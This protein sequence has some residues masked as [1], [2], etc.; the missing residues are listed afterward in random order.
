MATRSERYRY[1]QDESKSRV[2]RNR[3][4]Y[5]QIYANDSY[6]QNDESTPIEHTNEINI[7]KVKELL[8]GREI[9]RREMK[10]RELNMLKPEKEDVSAVESDSPEK[11]YDIN[12]YLT[13]ASSERTAEPYHKISPENLKEPDIELEE[14]KT[15]EPSLEELHEMGTTALSLDM[16]NDLSSTSEL[17]NTLDE[18]D[19]E[20]LVATITQTEAFFTDSVKLNLT[21]DEED[22]EENEKTSTSVKIIVALLI[23][24]IIAL[25]VFLILM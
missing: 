22:D 21:D 11:S 24:I 17:D 6:F 23:L 1:E 5:E 3:E 15:V 8:K 7:E 12:T 20:E 10:M 2:A 25:V 13:K 4:L 14:E 18:E 16:F 19:D 9:Y